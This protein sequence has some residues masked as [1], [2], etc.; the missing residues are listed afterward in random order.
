LCAQQESKR[1]RL[2]GE[3]ASESGNLP[4]GLSVEVY[5]MAGRTPIDK[6]PVHQRGSFEVNNLTSNQLEIRLVSFNGDVI[7]KE[8]V[9]L[10]S[11]YTP[12]TI[13]L[14][15][16]AGSQP[17][18]GTVSVGRLKHTPSK[19]A[20]K[21]FNQSQQ[22][23]AKGEIARSLELLQIAVRE[24]PLYLE[25][26]NNLGSYY[27]RAGDTDQALIALRRAQ[28]LDGNSPHVLTNLGIV[29]LHKKQ[30]EEAEEVARRA[31]RQLR[32]DTK[33][34]YVLGLSLFQG[35][36]NLDEALFYLEKAKAEFPKARLNIAHIL[37][38]AGNIVQAR[39]ELE[40]YL[41]V[42]SEREGFVRK[43]LEAL[44]KSDHTAATAPHD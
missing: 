31:I 29:L 43:W 12:V 23:F 36:K 27:M 44:P 11:G 18:E 40:Q 19:K 3:V 38:R 21:V 26:W 35:Q 37:V 41:A 17:L 16:P 13:R 24:D 22:A 4:H 42:S 32:S 10:G 6:V 2:L 30:R 1:F 33:A 28:S 14:P 34:E 9:N 15:S 5:D 39:Q 7:R 20:R 8:Y 25:A